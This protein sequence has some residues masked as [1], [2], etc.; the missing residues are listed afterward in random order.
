MKIYKENNELIPAIVIRVDG[1]TPPDNFTEVTDI[2]EVEKYG[3][4]GI[5][6]KIQGWR[7]KKA[8]RDKLKT[9]IYTKMGVI[10]MADTEND[11]KFNLLTPQEK[12]IALHWCLLG[13][14]E[15]QVAENSDDKYWT[16]IA[17]DY[18]AWSTT[19]K[20]EG[21]RQKRLGR[22]ESLVFRRLLYLYEAKD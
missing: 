21:A 17:S 12:S 3:L 11:T 8:V 16:D 15:W 7:D 10:T 22:M 14:P 19:G 2:V 20:V 1:D 4:S 5:N 18:R 9:L 13:K 6:K